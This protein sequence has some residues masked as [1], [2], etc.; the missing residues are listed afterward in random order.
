MR[1][2]AGSFVARPALVAIGGGVVVGIV[3]HRVV[4]NGLCLMEDAARL[5][6]SHLGGSRTGVRHIEVVVAPR[7]V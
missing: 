7:G 6:C 1:S 2:E 4:S 5:S 3:A